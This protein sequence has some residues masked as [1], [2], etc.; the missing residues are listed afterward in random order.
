MLHFVPISDI[1]SY[2]VRFLP[3]FL[4]FCKNINIFAKLSYYIDISTRNNSFTSY[5]SDIFCSTSVYC[6]SQCI[7]F[8]LLDRR[9]IDL[10]ESVDDVVFYTPRTWE[11]DTKHTSL[12]QVFNILLIIDWY[13]IVQQYTCVVYSFAPL[14]YRPSK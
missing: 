11:R 14:A 3:F 5:S 7:Y 1:Q 4:Q 12:V 10:S 6:N 9:I 13:S 2:Y 8:F